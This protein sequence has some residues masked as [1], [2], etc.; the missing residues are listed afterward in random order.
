MIVI[1]C[2]N[3]VVLFRVRPPHAKQDGRIVC[4]NDQVI[5]AQFTTAPASTLAAI[6]SMAAHA[7]QLGGAIQ[8]I[9]DLSELP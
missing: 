6:K 1:R 3:E 4:A 8:Q 7:V 5:V 9:T 2:A